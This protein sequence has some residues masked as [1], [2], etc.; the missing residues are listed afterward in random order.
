MKKILCFILILLNIFS[1]SL[2]INAE[3]YRIEDNKEI[4]INLD[5]TFN[6]LEKSN[7]DIQLIDKKIQ[8]A[9]KQHENAMK[10]SKEA[11]E[12]YSYNENVNLQYR[13]DEKLNWRITKLEL[14]VLNNEKAN[15]LQNLRYNLKQQ[16]MNILLLDNEVEIL[17][18]ELVDAEKKLKETETRIKLGQLKGIDL[19]QLQ[20]QILTLR[21]QINEINRQKETI[22]IDFKKNLGIDINSKIKLVKLNLPYI[23]INDTNLENIIESKANDNFEVYKSKQQLENKEIEKQLTIDYSS[24]RNSSSIYNIEL[25]LLELETQINQ[26]IVNTKVD[27]WNEYYNIQ[28][29]KENIAIEELNLDIEKINYDSIK[30]KSKLGIIDTATESNA[31]IAYNRQKNNLQRAMYEYILAV[32]QFNEKLDIQQ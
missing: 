27:L 13:K 29:L 30:A 9:S 12:K 16:Y 14:E 6:M 26:Q 5:D 23:Y 10:A 25:S 32:E 7:L 22:L 18:A 20:I 24:N 2:S 15:L 4:L 21:S 11:T 31:R 8:L 17:N 19:K 1:Y 3:S 28:V